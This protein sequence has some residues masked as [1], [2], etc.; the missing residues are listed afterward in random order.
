M[1]DRRE[2]YK[3]YNANRKEQS[4]TYN[5]ERY[6]ENKD[7]ILTQQKQYR[8]DNKDKINTHRQ[9]KIT[10]D[11]CGLCVSRHHLARHKTTKKCMNNVCE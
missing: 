3:Q 1:A 5:A 6:Q 2:Y 8:L 10:C 9:E 7:D 4:K 11:V